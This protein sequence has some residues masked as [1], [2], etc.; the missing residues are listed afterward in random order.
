MLFS[1]HDKTGNNT[2]FVKKLV[3][4]LSSLDDKT[5]NSAIFSR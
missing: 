5:G 3:I 1:V 2:I 4:I